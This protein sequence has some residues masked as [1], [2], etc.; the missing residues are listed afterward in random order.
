MTAIAVAAVALAVEIGWP[1]GRRQV[2]QRLGLVRPRLAVPKRLPLWV[3]APVALGLLV[4]F[5][6]SHVLV[7]VAGGI[8][9]VTA[10]RV[11]TASRARGQA[12][13]RRLA[14]VEAVSLLAAE[15][16]AGALPD[17][18]L[19]SAAADIELLASA[20]RAATHGADVVAALRAAGEQPG[21]ELLDHLASAWWLADRA[22]ASLSSVLT[23]LADRARDDLDLAAEVAAEL[24]PARATARLMAVLPAFGLAL[25]SG[26]GGDP[27]EVLLETTAG[28]ICLVLGVVFA[29]AG[30]MWVEQVAAAADR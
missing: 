28:G 19:R 10:V 1:S 22:G 30:V 29:C 25:G 4:W 8:G 20:A 16:R 23:R 9:G 11:L 6:G 14:A 24:A 12:R 2:R 26:L 17:V 18:A 13:A 21:A 27:V 7:V 5:G 3:V 15:V